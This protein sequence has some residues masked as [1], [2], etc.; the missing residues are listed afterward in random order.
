HRGARVLV[1]EDNPVN[2][3]VLLAILHGVGLNVAVAA[4]GQEAVAL[5]KSGDY[6]MALMDMQMPVM[7]GLQATRALRALPDWAGKPILA[8]TA[9]AFDVDRQ[10]CKD[11]G[12]D[13]FIIKPVDVNALYATVLNWLDGSDARAGPLLDGPGNGARPPNDVHR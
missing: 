5:A 2:Q 13:D 3:E 1:A 4:N 12:M 11:A 10:A 9:N 7:G 8:L 6:S